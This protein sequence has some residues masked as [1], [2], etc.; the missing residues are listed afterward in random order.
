[1]RILYNLSGLL[2]DSDLT[3]LML[4]VLAFRYAQAHL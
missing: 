2:E 3:L 1:M 4:V